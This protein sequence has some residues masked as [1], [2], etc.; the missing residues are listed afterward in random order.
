MIWERNTDKVICERKVGLG[1]LAPCFQ[2]E[3]TKHSH[4]RAFM[5][6]DPQIPNTGIVR[7]PHH[8]SNAR[9]EILELAQK[10]KEFYCPAHI[11]QSMFNSFF[12]FFFL[13]V[14]SL[15]II[16]ALQKISGSRGK[17]NVCCLGIIWS[18]AF[19]EDK[20][21]FKSACRKSILATRQLELVIKG[22][23]NE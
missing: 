22:M 15:H 20:I 3:P 13:I 2:M 23:S 10:N 16:P 8:M 21:T 12:F 18:H 6:G 4:P 19:K 11:I 5:D 14:L 1:L 7:N 17:F 9:K